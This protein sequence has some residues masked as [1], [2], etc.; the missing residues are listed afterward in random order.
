MKRLYTLGT[1]CLVL[2]VLSSVLKFKKVNDSDTFAPYTLYHS[3]AS[4]QAKTNKVVNPKKAPI[5]NEKV[6]L[7]KKTSRFFYQA[8]TG[9]C[10]NA[11][12]DRGFN[13]INLSTLFDGLNENEL[14][15][16]N[17]QP[18]QVYENKDAECTDF[19]KFDF[20]RIIKLSYVRLT[21]WNFKGSKLDGAAFAFAKMIDADLQGAKLKDISIGYTYISGQIDRFTEYP[22]VCILK[23]FGREQFTQHIRCEL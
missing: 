22:D 13:K 3:E 16:P 9:E 20:N 6:G 5:E 17:Y 7:E 21:K 15:S 1:I 14:S 18:K 4:A 10:V 8:K 23:R 19:S 11:K 12:G 2:I